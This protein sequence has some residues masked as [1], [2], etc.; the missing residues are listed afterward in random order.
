MQCPSGRDQ[1]LR[2]RNRAGS[3]PNRSYLVVRTIGEAPS[4]HFEGQILPSQTE[5]E[6]EPRSRN[7]G[8]MSSGFDLV[9]GALT[10]LCFSALLLGSVTHAPHLCSAW[11]MQ[12][13][14]LGRS[15]GP[16]NP[17]LFR[18][19][20]VQTGLPWIRV[21]W[22]LLSNRQKFDFDPGNLVSL[23]LELKLG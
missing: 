19:I 18:P 11:C 4:I 2:Q 3:I 16:C 20:E 10:Q 14:S 21:F 6:L 13:K 22:G 23:G 1:K 8:F 12:H 15:V 5:E 17:T 7:V 9:T